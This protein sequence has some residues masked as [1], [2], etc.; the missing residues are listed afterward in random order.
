[1]TKSI[2]LQETV[3]PYL[4]EGQAYLVVDEDKES[5]VIIDSKK[6]YHFI[7]KNSELQYTIA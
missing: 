4:I 3:K 1:M 2:I 7:K 5:Y 6:Q